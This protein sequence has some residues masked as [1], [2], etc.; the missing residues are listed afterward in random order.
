MPDASAESPEVEL[1]T[2]DGAGRRAGLVT[3]DQGISSA[4]NLLLLIWAAHAL[5]AADF[6]RFSLVLF[7]WAFTQS[8]V[9][10]ALVA[11]TV[12]VHPE[13]ADE[14]PRMVLGA[15]VLLSLAAGLL[16]VVGGAVTWWAGSEIGPPLV[17]VGL[18]MPL[19]GVQDAGRYM[20]VAE[21]KPGRA[22]VLDTIWLVVMVVAF[23]AVIYGPGASLMW[24]VIAWAGSG[25]LAGAWVFVQHGVPRAR[26]LSLDWLRERWHFSWRSLV[27]SS[28]SAVVALVGSSLL[29]LV[30]GPLAVAAIRA[31][32]LL[33]RPSTTIQTAVATSA[34]ADIA[35][36]Q[37]DDA[38]LMRHQRRALVAAVVVAIINMGVLLI[39]PD[40]I[41][42]LVLGN[43]WKLVEPLLFVIGIHICT[44]AAQ[45]G[46]RAALIG[47]R[48]IHAVMIV[49]IAGTVLAIAG[50]VI[51]AVFADAQGAMWGAVV[52]Q[53]ITAAIWWVALR[54]YLSGLGTPAA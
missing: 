22:I 15:S 47:R 35:R 6:G 25:A 20:G 46:V 53:A 9:V 3:I 39:I 7:A 21:S 12:V 16:C 2:R 49:D 40:S 26:E 54:R 36:E 43:V 48:Q 32:L 18:L 1:P 5:S 14:R 38:A 4:S 31:A 19:L 13:D 27:A 37:S 28:S 11:A 17:L 10:R 29:A 24:L 23:G 50:L 34:T 41:G 45:S 52:G 51:G 33:E 44:L 42:R 8:G 30:S